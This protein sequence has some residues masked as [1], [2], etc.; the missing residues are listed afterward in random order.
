MLPICSKTLLPASPGSQTFGRGGGCHVAVSSLR[1]ANARLL[2]VQERG[3]SS[4]YRRQWYNGTSRDLV[5]KSL[6]SQ[7]MVESFH[8][9][10]KYFFCNLDFILFDWQINRNTLTLRNANKQKHEGMYQ[11]AATNVHGSSLSA[12]Q[13]RVLCKEHYLFLLKSRMYKC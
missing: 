2:M 4:A 12:A 11:C 9:I 13:I 5:T 3:P 8:R 1:Q 7:S 10:E 6:I